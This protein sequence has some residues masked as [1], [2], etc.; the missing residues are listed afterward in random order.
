MCTAMREVFTENRALLEPSAALTVAAAKAYAAQHGLRDRTLVA[1][2][3]GANMNFDRLGFVVER[4]YTGEH[5]EAL[6]AITVPRGPGAV[7]RLVQTIGDHNVSELAYRI[8]GEDV[9]HVFAG[10]YVSGR[11][12]TEATIAALEAAGFSTTDLSDNEL[13]KAHLRHFCGGRS[14]KSDEEGLL[15]DELIFRLDFPEAPGAF[16]AFLRSVPTEWTITAFHYRNH[17]ADHG[18]A[19]VGFNVP[20]DAAHTLRGHLAATGYGVVEE[21]DNP[22]YPLFL[23]RE[24][25]GHA[26]PVA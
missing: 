9:A 16:G 8:A 26:A 6:L 10:I 3:C 13:A 2:L 23:L 20:P 15:R 19:L 5:R 12:D 1:V 22:A 11:A 7:A 17:G 14:M 25:D 4:S 21:A 24:G 18:S